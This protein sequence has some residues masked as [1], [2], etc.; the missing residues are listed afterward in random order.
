M[1]QLARAPVSPPVLALWRPRRATPAPALADARRILVVH[2]AEAGDFVLLS[3]FLR[4]L[5]R[6]APAARITLVVRP[7]V[8]P[9]AEGCPHVQEVLVYPAP[10]RRPPGPY[11]RCWRAWRFARLRLRPRSFDLA[12]LPRWGVDAWGAV[13]L[14]FFSGA[15]RR[16]GFS[17]RSSP[18]KSRWNRGD[19][20]LL[21]EALVAEGVRH[22]VL[23][24]LDL[25]EFAGGGARE[26]RL[27]CWPSPS[28]RQ[29]AA[30]AAAELRARAPG[31][32]LVALAP[33][34]GEP[35]RAWPAD[36]FAA[37]GERLAA[38]ADAAVAIIGGAGEKEMAERI[39]GGLQCPATS[40][41]GRLNWPQTAAF[42]EHCALLVTN[43]SGP[44]HLAA[45]A[46]TP[47]VVLSC[48]PRGGSPASDHAPER[49]APWGVEHAV[50][51]PENFAGTC[52]RECRAAA[53]HC[54]TG[55]PREDVVRAS[56]RML[57][58]RDSVKT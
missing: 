58:I 22:E 14:L 47:V 53:A 34:A 44:A 21:T 51:R 45:A 55:I 40:L 9:L 26:T 32:R 48:H 41:A 5:R 16:I 35:K 29:A 28:D 39:R 17:E 24:S 3:A 23:R 30:Q 4:E 33:G 2:L 36:R 46:G 54:I 37:V 15:P 12:L 50:L 8:H 19:D 52:E 42:L 18:E 10:E 13:Q 20:R 43:D 57:G 56:A 25:L 1:R 38:E 27:E 31:R 7:A 11:R 49:F 6:S